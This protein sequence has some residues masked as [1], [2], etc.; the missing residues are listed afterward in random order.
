M[1]RIYGNK[2]AQSIAGTDA[3]SRPKSLP[4]LDRATPLR[5]WTDKGELNDARLLSGH[6]RLHCAEHA[7]RIPANV[8]AEMA[9]SVRTEQFHIVAAVYFGRN[10]GFARVQR[11]QNCGSPLFRYVGD[12]VSV[13]VQLVALFAALRP[14]K[15][16]VA[17][18]FLFRI[19][20]SLVQSKRPQTCFDTF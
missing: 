12:R 10:Y 2:R 19:Y 14:S 16:L 3:E 1:L 5:R 11:W 8:P 9:V 7:A 17:F 4:R 15:P 6:H 18:S 20:I 13:V